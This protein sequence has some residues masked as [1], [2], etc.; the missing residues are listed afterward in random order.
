MKKVAPALPPLMRA[1]LVAISLIVLALLAPFPGLQAIVHAALVLGLAVD[2][3]SS[4]LTALYAAAAGWTLEGSA[5]MYPHLGGTAWADMSL[6]LV[7]ASLARNWP[8]KAW[9]EWWPRLLL[10]HILQ[11]LLVH[12]A[13]RIACGPAPWGRAWSWSLLTVPAWGWLLWRWQR[14]RR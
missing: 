1:L 5:R 9:K 6:A 8:P 3:G 13:V 14:P 4:L 10:L 7:A 12:I 2:P 11:I